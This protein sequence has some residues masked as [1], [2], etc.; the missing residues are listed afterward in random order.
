MLTVS[1]LARA[2]GRRANAARAFGWSLVAMAAGDALVA[3]DVSFVLSGAATA[4][5]FSLAADCRG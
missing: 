3:F 2:L 5:L 4:G 1:F